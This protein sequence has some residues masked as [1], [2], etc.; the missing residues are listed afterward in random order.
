M[1]RVAASDKSFIALGAALFSVGVGYGAILPL[2]PALLRELLPT[3]SREAASFHTGALAAVYMMAVVALAPL[4][5]RLSD[6]YGRRRILLLGMAGYAL[7]SIA[8]AWADSMMQTYALRFAAGASAGAVLPAVL[9]TASELED[10]ERRASRLAWLGAAS[11]LGYLV[12]PA[13]SGAIDALLQPDTEWPFYVAAGV[14]VAALLLTGVTLPDAAPVQASSRE[15]P[16][17]SSY[18]LGRVAALS[19]GAMFGLGAFE[20]G[21]TVLAAQRLSLG[22]GALA[23][24]FV[25]CSLV[26]L[27]VQAW[28]ALLP[29]AASHRA[30]AVAAASF[31]CMTVG[32]GVL[33]LARS[34]ELVYVGVALLA[35]GSGALL[36]L[37]TFLASL[38]QTI[39]L[40]AAIGI[41]TA[42]AN[43]GQAGGS[44]AAG[45]LYGAANRE[46]FWIYAALMAL[47]AGIA[48]RR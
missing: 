44:A 18:S 42:A 16:A 29:A 10:V 19:T 23:L 47:G 34:V 33:A 9:A 43:L 32:F 35:A 27:I 24:M 25:E 14:A 1:H 21:L 30:R 26:M 2:V 41:Q 36:P 38:P 15:A 31:A 39:G 40:G 5:G 12:G 3:A 37:L 28:L 11:L 6:R 22:T 7:A 20:V 4:W 45:W 13:L 17:S 46:S 8:L 48:A